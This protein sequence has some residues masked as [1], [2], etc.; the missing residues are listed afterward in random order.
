MTFSATG[1][2]AFMAIEVIGFSGTAGSSI[3][4]D[5]NQ[6]LAGAGTTCQSASITPSTA[7]QVVVSGSA[8]DGGVSSSYS[9]DSG[10][11]VS[12]SDPFTA[13]V[14]YGGALAYIIETSAVAKQ[15]T[16]TSTV[17]TTRI[18]CMTASFK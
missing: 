3:D 5:S 1:G 10:L 9:V 14:N 6:T 12:D 18:N 11:T 7:N 2:N 16:W 8:Y 17:T 15:P 13:G 4:Q